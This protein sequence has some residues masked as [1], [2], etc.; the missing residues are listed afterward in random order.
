MRN[1][2]KEIRDKVNKASTTVETIRSSTT[3]TIDA[4]MVIATGKAE[5]IV[6]RRTMQ[7]QRAYPQ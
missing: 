6:I 4:K 7:T 1:A 2:Q 3:T 5:T